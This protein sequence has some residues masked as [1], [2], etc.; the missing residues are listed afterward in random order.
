MAD[1]LELVFLS[2]LERRG[3]R[4]LH[5]ERLHPGGSG[6]IRIEIR[7]SVWLGR[8]IPAQLPGAPGYGHVMFLICPSSFCGEPRIRDHETRQR[9]W[10]PAP[11]HRSGAKTEA[12]VL[13][14][15]NTR[16]YEDIPNWVAG[17]IDG[18]IIF[19]SGATGDYASALSL[20]EHRHSVPISMGTDWLINDM[21]MT[22]VALEGV[23][24][25]APWLAALRAGRSW[26]TNGTLLDF[27]VDDA[28]PGASRAQWRH[29]EGARSAAGRNDFL[30]VELVVNETHRG[31]RRFRGDRRW[32]LPR[33]LRFRWTGPR[34]SPRGSRRFAGAMIAR[35]YWA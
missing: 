12:T 17:L 3:G 20:F 35:K 22:M 4:D 9:R 10:P 2:Y 8:G 6:S 7:H 18:R 28:A 16:G 13:W 31:Q 30:G 23:A 14:C 5:I 34:G 27:S 32:F 19:D 21:A 26:I 33:R 1:R 11:R 29:G 25:T 15:H 24:A